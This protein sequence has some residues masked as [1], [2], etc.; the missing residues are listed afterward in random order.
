MDNIL[1]YFF[2]EPEKE[3]HVRELA[4]L[5]KKSPTTMSKYLKKLKK[6]EILI[7]KSERNHLLFRANTKNKKFESLKF[8][9]N[10][11][12]IRKSGLVDYLIEEFNNPEAIILFGSFRKAENNSNSDID[13]LVISSSKKKPN[14]SK[15]EKKLNHKIQLFVHSNKELNDMKI[16]NKELLNNFLNGFILEGYWGLF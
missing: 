1:K 6:Q 11:D 12:I 8:N 10:T 16:R 7:S 9:Y 5:T 2:E 15:F 3:F 13:L 14:L 4:K